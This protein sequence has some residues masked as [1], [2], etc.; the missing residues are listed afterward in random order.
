MYFDSFSD[1]LAMGDHGFY[2]WLAYGAYLILIIWNLIG[3]GLRRRQV[4]ESLGRYWR[5]ELA[6][7]SDRNQ[8]DRKAE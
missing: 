1:F 6:N 7:S 8:E 5:R 4:L 3:A 2:V